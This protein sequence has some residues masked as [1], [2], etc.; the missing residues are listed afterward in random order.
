[1]RIRVDEI[2]DLG[3]FLHLHWDQSQLSQFI[4]PDDPFEIN[5]PHPVNVDLELNKFPDH[6]RIQGTLQGELQVNCHRCLTPVR[7]S[8]NEPID[9]FLFS[10][11]KAPQ[12]DE[13]ELEAED[14]D[15][16]YFDGEVIDIDLLI[17]EQ[18]FLALP[19]KVLCSENCRGLCPGCGVNLNE[20]PCRCKK[21]KE[22][23][24]SKLEEI[25]ARL[26]G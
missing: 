4:P 1:M 24:F 19:F 16:S 17:A 10:E 18:I 21:S 14:L 11:E 6:I 5:L 25:K 22:T 7:L 23:P 12:E 15:Y 8:L 20:E 3:R 2:P 26:P 9:L 13:I